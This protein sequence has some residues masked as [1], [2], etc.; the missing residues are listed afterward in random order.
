MT[1]P[2]DA[3]TPPP[4]AAEMP[5]LDHLEELRWRL[6]YSLAALAVGLVIAFAL[7]SKVDVIGFLAQP[8]R[9][10]LKPGQTLVFTHPSDVFSI[11]LNASLVLG[12]VLASPVIAYQVWAFLSP[13]LYTHEKKVIVPVLLGAVLLFVAGVALAFKVI[14]PITLGFLLTFQ[15]GS[16]TP[17]LTAGEYFGFA[18]SMSLAL[19]AVFELPILILALTALGLVTPAL[20]NRFRRHAVVGCV[21]GAAF[22]TPGADPTSLFVLAGPLYLLFEV[23]VILSTFVH[24]RRVRRERAREAAEATALA[25]EQAAA[26]RL[27]EQA[28]DSDAAFASID[29]AAPVVA[30]GASTGPR[31]LGGPPDG[32]VPFDQAGL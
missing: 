24:R 32:S 8:V 14:L 5:F 16:L 9:P 30:S 26:A 29:T 19:G 11:V 17:M 1:L 18:T 15:T 2:P 25:A 22:I 13:A 7:I 12:L 4:G 23:S 6:V 10:Y 20:L 21:V 31:R 3:P 28:A 27:E